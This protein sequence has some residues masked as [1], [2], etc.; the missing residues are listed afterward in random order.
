[1]RSTNEKSAKLSKWETLDACLRP[2]VGRLSRYDT[3]REKL[4]REGGG[5]NDIGMIAE[6]LDEPL[7]MHDGAAG[8]HTVK[9]TEHESLRRTLGRIGDHDVCFDVRALPTGMPAYYICRTRSDFWAS[10]TFI[11][12]DIYRSPGYPSFDDRFSRLMVLGRECH[13]LRLSH[14]RDGVGRMFG[15]SIAL[16]RDEVDDVLHRMGRNVLQ[17]AWHE[18]QLS[19]VLTAEH[20]ALRHFRDA[21]ELLYLCLSCDLCELRSGIDGEMLQ[22]FE[23]VYPQPAIKT[24]LETLGE[25]RG[26]DLNGIGRRALTCYA[27]LSREYAAFLSTGVKWRSDR[28]RHPLFKLVFANFYRLE[29]LAGLTE[30]N[31]GLIEG[32][33]RLE[34]SSRAVISEVIGRDFALAAA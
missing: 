27:S 33:E 6:L 12:E 24:F 13:Y 17:R 3:V 8:R 1:M 7:I 21:I 25:A 22:F 31:A 9:L 5:V 18:D 10:Y 29:S 16:G 32:C 4:E 20:F 11:V 14:L 34:S 15:E 30:M 2:L 28:P 26:S 23:T 19:G